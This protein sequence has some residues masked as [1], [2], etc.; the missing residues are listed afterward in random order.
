M[1]Q[2]VLCSKREFSKMH[3]YAQLDIATSAHFGERASGITQEQIALI[4]CSG[5]NSECTVERQRAITKQL[6]R[7]NEIL[8]D[9]LSFVQAVTR[10]P[11]VQLFESHTTAVGKVSVSMKNLSESGVYLSYR[12]YLLSSY[13]APM[14]L[15]PIAKELIATAL[16]ATVLELRVYM[17]W[18][19]W[20]A[21]ATTI[22]IPQDEVIRLESITA[23]QLKTSN[24]IL[25]NVYAAVTKRNIMKD[26]KEKSSIYSYF[27]NQYREF[28]NGRVSVFHEIEWFKK[29]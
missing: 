8:L 23:R 13:G 6:K 19:Q 25:R 15:V 4:F 16:F 21:L 26:A 27:K 17:R 14:F 20:L 5:L 28:Q 12:Q 7:W 3:E 10:S 18:L 1:P 9:K 2:S 29:D 24:R 11:I 22:E